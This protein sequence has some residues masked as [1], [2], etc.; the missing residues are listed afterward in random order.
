MDPETVGLN[1]YGIKDNEGKE[2]VFDSN[3]FHLM[4]VRMQHIS[5]CQGITFI[6]RKLICSLFESELKQVTTL[7]IV[8]LYI[9]FSILDS[10]VF[11][12]C[13]YQCIRRPDIFHPRRCLVSFKYKF[14]LYNKIIL[15]ISKSLSGGIQKHRTSSNLVC[16]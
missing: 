9:K 10:S 15:V 5:T 2:I 1:Q 11:P 3:G 8:L 14:Q 6:I 12:V 7:Y 13:P 4:L 16:Y